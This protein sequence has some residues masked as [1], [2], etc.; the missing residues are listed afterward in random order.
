MCVFLC[1]VSGL[2]PS[3][4]RSGRWVRIIRWPD[5]KTQAIHE[6]RGRNLLSHEEVEK[7]QALLAAATRRPWFA[8]VNDLIGGRCVQ[9]V[10]RPVS[11]APVGSGVADMIVRDADA[12][13]YLITWLRNHGDD[14]LR[15]AFWMREISDLLEGSSLA[16][17]LGAGVASLPSV[18]AKLISGYRTDVPSPESWDL[19]TSAFAG[20]QGYGQVFGCGGDEAVATMLEEIGMPNTAAEWR[21]SHREECTACK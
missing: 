7:G 19:V 18:V 2:T 21:T 20:Y 4:P 5:R 16:S 11:E 14:L 3:I 13:A 9:T 1:R 6:R 10:E 15:A 8:A 12:D 17:Q